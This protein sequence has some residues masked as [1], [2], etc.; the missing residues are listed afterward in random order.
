MLTCKVG[1]NIINCFDGIYD[2]YQFKKW[3]DKNIL[4]C[5]DC[6]KPYEYCHGQIIPPY[7]RHK[8]K[9]KDCEGLYSEPETKEHIDGKL[10]LYKWLLSLQEHGI[11]QNVKLEA[12][13]SETKQRPDIY[14]EQNNKRFV[15][16]YQCSPIATEY[17][18][19]HELYKLANVNDIWILGINKYNFQISEDFIVHNQ[20]F[21]TIE[22][23][24]DYHLNTERKTL[25]IKKSLIK[26]YLQY[27]KVF[28]KAYYEY[29]LDKF[30]I[31]EDNL[32]LNSEIIQDFI[33]RDSIAYEEYLKNNLEL[34]EKRK[35]NEILINKQK[36]IVNILNS[37]HPRMDGEF[38]FSYREGNPAYY[39]W[40]IEFVNEEREYTFF[41]KEDSIDCCTSYE[42]SSQ[43]EAF[44]RKKHKYTKRWGKR[45][46]YKNIDK[47][48]CVNLEETVT[49]DFILKHTLPIIEQCQLVF[50]EDEEKKNKYKV[51]YG[52][53]LD[54][55]IYLLNGNKEKSNSNIRF[56]FL[57]GFKVIDEYMETMFIKELQFLERIN[58]Q[59]LIFMIP[60]YNYYNNLGFENYVRV[61][62]F[63]DRI[64]EYFKSYGFTNIK[65]LED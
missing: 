32:I 35:L 37:M 62:D 33:L 58:A 51:I 54:K 45:T 3:S 27:N 44:S 29:S 28:L 61:D 1:E 8:E 36:D 57:K 48:E 30:D 60:R 23:H 11:V 31:K 25:Y 5:P 16:E 50:K 63:N 21:K 43:Y 56:K 38:Y 40:G 22:K 10:I 39:L 26:S 59:K 47:L 15:I 20:Y 42:Y 6:G 46:G 24:T 9:N 18:E 7:F 65:Y 55:E 4:I 13:I 34:E 49:I 53:L 64:L 17:L 2:K 52:D 14:F 12:Y 19:R 41:V